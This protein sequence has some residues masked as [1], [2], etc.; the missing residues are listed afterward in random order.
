MNEWFDLILQ[1]ILLFLRIFTR[2]RLEIIYL[3]FGRN[4]LKQ[5]RDTLP[6]MDS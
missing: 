3:M 5:T 1:G 2:T 4:T 6:V